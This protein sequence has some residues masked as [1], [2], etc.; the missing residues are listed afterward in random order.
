MPT[1]LQLNTEEFDGMKELENHD[2]FLQ[3]ASDKLKELEEKKPWDRIPEETNKAYTAFVIYLHFGTDRSLQKVADQLGKTKRNIEKWS[4][5]YKWAMRV[6][7]YDKEQAVFLAEERKKD[8]LNQLA[9][10][11]K[12]AQKSSWVAYNISKKV[13]DLAF[14][15]LM[16]FTEEDRAEWG[17]DTVLNMLK[18]SEIL[19]KNSLDFHA[20]SL[21]VA[22]LMEKFQLA[23]NKNGGNGNSSG[24]K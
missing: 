11:Q 1:E 12:H 24:G 5:K 14:N 19:E 2:K 4:S 15:C 10:F 18:V 16:Q 13:V 3:A 23:Q 22:E 20:A 8:H 6:D 17:I 21:G 9:Q 7:A